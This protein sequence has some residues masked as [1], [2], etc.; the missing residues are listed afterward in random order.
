MAISAASS[1][2]PMGEINMTP[3][4]DVMLVLLVMFII[5]IPLQTHAVKLDLPRDCST[6]GTIDNLKNKVVI[7]QDGQI[8][9][10]GTPVTLDGLK[11]NLIR[12][13]SIDPQPELHVQP[14]PTARY[15][16]VNDVFVA[17]KRADVRRLG[18]VGNE[19]YR[20]F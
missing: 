10:N 19:A 14:D 16:V 17:A 15:E 20:S 13:T 6:C 3:L 5:T 2:A 9:W 18:F 8:V 4:I 11:Y 12:M 7:T 1:S